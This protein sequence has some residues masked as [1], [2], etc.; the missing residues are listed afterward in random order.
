MRAVSEA[1]SPT[2]MAVADR[3]VETLVGQSTVMDTGPTDGCPS[4]DELEVAELDTVPQV[5]VVVG[6]VMVTVA[7]ALG[8]RSAGPKLSDPPDRVQPPD[9]LWMVQARPLSAGTVSATVT[10]WAVAL[11]AVLVTVSV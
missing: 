11:V 9:W 2:E 5:A 4:L 3:P 7:E 10:P 8:P 6:E 1:L